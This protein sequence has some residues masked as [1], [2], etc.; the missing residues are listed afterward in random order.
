MAGRVTGPN[1]RNDPP[2]ASDWGMVVRPIGPIGPVTFAQ[3]TLGT[4]TTVPAAAVATTL[5]LA[6]AARL[7]AI[8]EN[9]SASRFLY[10]K[11]AAGVT[12]SSYTVRLGPRS[13]FELP[14]PIYIGLIE[15]V[16]TAGVGGFAVVTELT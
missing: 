1:T 11:L 9:G 13:Y 2:V 4:V 12:S 10:V 6:N 8:I 3:P 5:L 7:G 14:F 15:G 16:W